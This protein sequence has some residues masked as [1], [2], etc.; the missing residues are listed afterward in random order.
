[1]RGKK[2]GF[3]EANCR[4]RAP[5][6]IRLIPLDERTAL[7]IG[8]PIALQGWLASASAPRRLGAVRLDILT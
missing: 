4:T 3:L 2:Q 7:A 1:M 8:S 5:T 6:G